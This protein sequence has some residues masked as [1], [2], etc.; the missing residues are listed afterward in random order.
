VSGIG[1]R[2]EASAAGRVLSPPGG[3]KGDDRVFVASGGGAGST[4]APFVMAPS[5][6]GDEI[7]GLP[8]LPA[9]GTGVVTPG[10]TSIGR[11]D[12]EAGGGAPAGLTGLGAAAFGTSGSIAGA[13]NGGGS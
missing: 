7:T 2:S 9:R 8:E 10:T 1:A 4:G 6:V 5:R 11:P 3:R 13:S 12:D